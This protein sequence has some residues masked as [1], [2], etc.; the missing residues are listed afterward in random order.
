PRKATNSRPRLT[1]HALYGMHHLDPGLEPMSPEV[2]HVEVVQFRLP[3]Q[4]PRDG[5]GDVW[6]VG[7]R[8]ANVES[9]R[10]Q[11]GAYGLARLD[12]ALRYPPVAV[13]VS[14]DVPSP[15]DDGP[16]AI[17]AVVAEPLFHLAVDLTLPGQRVLRRA[18]G[19]VGK[20]FRPEVVDRAGKH[21]AGTGYSSC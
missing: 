1:H 4:Q 14:E 7:P 13:P 6:Q 20:S 21:E 19:E 17:A 9:P 18:L 11:D 3:L 2:E 10:V 5:G 8:V 12:Q 16:L 15:N